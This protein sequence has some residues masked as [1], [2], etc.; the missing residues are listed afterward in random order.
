MQK[1]AELIQTL[2]NGKSI[3]IHEDS[4]GIVPSPL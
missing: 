2:M 1:E 4:N 3:Y